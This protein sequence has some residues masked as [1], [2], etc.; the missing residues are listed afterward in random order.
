MVH[1]LDV[2][3]HP[4]HFSAEKSRNV[5]VIW[6]KKINNKLS[7]ISPVQFPSSNEFAPNQSKNSIF[8]VGWVFCFCFCL[9]SELRIRGHGP[10]SL[11]SEYFEDYMGLSRCSTV[12]KASYDL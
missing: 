6:G 10:V 5:H 12:Y 9:H 11:S 8:R 3:Y 1:L 4:Q 7:H 2:T